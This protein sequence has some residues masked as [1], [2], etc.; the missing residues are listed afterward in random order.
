MQS[1]YVEKY[2]QHCELFYYG[3]LCLIK[4][5]KSTLI[6]QDIYYDTD[7][8]HHKKIIHVHRNLSAWS[9]TQKLTQLSQG[10]QYWVTYV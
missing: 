6:I 5:F 9:P 10:F 1:C 2:L 4:N 8:V 7:T 3:I